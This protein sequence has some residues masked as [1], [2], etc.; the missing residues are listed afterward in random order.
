MKKRG[1]P[2][3]GMMAGYKYKKVACPVCGKP[4]AENW[5]IRHLKKYHPVRKSK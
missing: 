3:S 1:Q 4:V 5:C 2:K